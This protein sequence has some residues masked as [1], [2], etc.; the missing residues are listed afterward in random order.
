MA[1]VQAAAVE[2]VGGEPPP[3]SLE[4]DRVGGTPVPKSRTV[5]IGDIRYP[6]PVASDARPWATM[7]AD[8]EEHGIDAGGLLKCV[9]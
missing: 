7:V 6:L 3:T 2:A 5:R 4:A 1:I 9:C 8:L